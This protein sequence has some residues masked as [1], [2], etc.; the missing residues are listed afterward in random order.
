MEN[1]LHIL[2][3]IVWQICK[4]WVLAEFERVRANMRLQVISNSILINCSE[5]NKAKI[6]DIKAYLWYRWKFNRL[7]QI[8]KRRQHS[9]IARYQRIPKEENWISSAACCRLL[10]TKRL[11]SWSCISGISLYSIHKTWI[12]PFL[13]SWTVSI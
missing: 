1:D 2:A 13:H 6:F 5:R 10:V 3:K 11:F 4:L 9:S 12:W 8:L 7:F